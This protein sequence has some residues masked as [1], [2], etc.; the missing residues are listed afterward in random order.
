LRELAERVA[1][2]LGG[3]SGESPGFAWVRVPPE[4]MLEAAR[5]IRE[6]GLEHVKAVTAID[7]PEEGE[8]EVVYHASSYEPGR[9]GVLALRTSVPRDD[10]RLPSLVGV[11]P[12]AEYMERE[13]WEMLGVVFEGHPRLERLLLP[14]DFEGVHPLRKDYEV[15]TA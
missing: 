4:K 13:Q 3:E 14:E 5:M 7:R 10:P 2:E 15:R 8:I 12:S 11:W 6:A 9:R 1:S